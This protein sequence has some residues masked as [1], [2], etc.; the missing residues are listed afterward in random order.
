MENKVHFLLLDNKKTQIV[1]KY[2]GSRP[3]APQ[4]LN[5]DKN[6]SQIRDSHQILDGFDVF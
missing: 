5:C 1:R 6:N 3:L 2:T 4:I